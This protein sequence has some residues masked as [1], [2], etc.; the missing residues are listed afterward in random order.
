[1]L[2]RLKRASMLANPRVTQFTIATNFGLVLF[3]NLGTNNLRLKISE[4]IGCSSEHNPNKADT[5]LLAL[6]RHS[7]IPPLC[8]LMGQVISS[9][10]RLILVIIIYLMRA[11]VENTLHGLEIK[12]TCVCISR[13]MGA[14][15][16]RHTNSFCFRAFLHCICELFPVILTKPTSEKNIY[17]VL[18]LERYGIYSN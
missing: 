18:F 11:E 16:D 9:V 7:Y 5:T 8:G 15:F 1:M 13:L 10:N 4:Y 17:V 14:C 2:I 3:E 6:R 12:C